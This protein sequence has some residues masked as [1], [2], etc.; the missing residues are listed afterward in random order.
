MNFE[1]LQ[2]PEHEI[3]VINGN[4]VVGKIISGEKTF[5]KIDPK[6]EGFLTPT[7][8]EEIL[9]TMVG[10]SA[11]RFCYNNECAF[12]DDGGYRHLSNGLVEIDGDLFEMNGS[13]LKTVYKKPR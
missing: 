7:D 12:I 11:S 9:D 2:E 10:T 1:K 5:F 6:Y 3:I 8:I 13:M 4:T